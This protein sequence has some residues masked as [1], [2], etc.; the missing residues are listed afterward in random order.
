MVKIAFGLATAHDQ[1]KSYLI[2]ADQFPEAAVRYSAYRLPHTVINGRVH[3]EGVV[4]ETALIKHLAQAVK[5]G[6]RKDV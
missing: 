3:I 2:M 4:D 1:I 5:T 6:G